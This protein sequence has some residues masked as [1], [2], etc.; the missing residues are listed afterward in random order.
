MNLHAASGEF[1]F[2]KFSPDLVLI[3][4]LVVAASIL[5]VVGFNRV[6]PYIMHYST[7]DYWFECDSPAVVDQMLQSETKYHYRTSHHPLFSILVFIPVYVLRTVLQLGPEEAVCFVLAF[8]AAVWITSFFICLRAMGLRRTDS[9]VFTALAATSASVVFWFPIP[10]TFVF[11]ALSIILALTVTAFSE[12]NYNFS[13]WIYLALS[14]IT[15]S[16]TSTNWIVGLAMLFVVLGWV[17]AIPLSLMSAGIVSILWNIQRVIFPRSGSPL[18]IFTKAETIY[19]F[20]KEALGL[21]AKSSSFFFHSIILPEVKHAYGYRLSV[22]GML[23][24]SGSY[25]TAAGVACWGALL[26]LAGWSAIRLRTSKIVSVLLLAIIGQFVVSMVFGVETFL[27]SAHFGPLLV[28]FSALSMLTPARRLAVPIGVVLVIVAG[29]NN[30]QK[31]DA[32]AD[33]LKAE[34]QNE[35]RFSARALELT[36]SDSLIVCGREA[37][38]TIGEQGLRKLDPWKEPAHEIMLDEEKQIDPGTCL[39]RFKDLHGKRVGWVIIYE[40][41]SMKNIETFRKRGAKY[42]ITPYAYGWQNNPKLFQTMDRRFRKLEKTS[43]WV[44]YDLEP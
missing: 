32:A 33:S 8:V 42:F 14:T 17:K 19:L 38:A 20:N 22:Q 31:F 30:I 18:D 26:A 39:F 16:F 44:F 43:K 13:L 27:Y 10:E 40:D 1:E 5:V 35:Y 6:S 15:L 36:D 21:F 7:W 2:R 41:W 29:V 11:G 24:G 23:P 28:L 3:V 34:Y 9:L 4:V 25:L 37:A 12:R